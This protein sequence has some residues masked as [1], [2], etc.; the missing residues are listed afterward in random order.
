MTVFSNS[1]SRKVG[2]PVAGL[3]A[4]AASAWAARV[5]EPM[6]GWGLVVP[7][8]GLV[9]VVLALSAYAASWS[10]FLWLS[11]VAVVYGSRFVL[12]GAERGLLSALGVVSSGGSRQVS[13]R[14]RS[15]MSASLTSS[16]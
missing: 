12:R 11:G 2:S 10:C 13:P 9:L 1:G 16:R 14:S 15:Y 8:E 7:V 6:L 3:S 4:C 5:S